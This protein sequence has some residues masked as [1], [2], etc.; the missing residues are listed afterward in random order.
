MLFGATYEILR[1]GPLRPYLLG[2][3]GAIET[4]D[5]AV[6]GTAFLCSARFCALAN[7]ARALIVEDERPISGAAHIGAGAAYTWRW[8]SLVGEARYFA[9]TNG[10]SRGLNGALPV[11]LGVR[12]F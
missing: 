12:L 7:S 8:I 3:I 11:S 2:G 10:I 5:E 1:E 6:R 9:V 4:H